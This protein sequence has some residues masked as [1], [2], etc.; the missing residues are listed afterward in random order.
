ME[1]RQLV[2]FRAVARSLSFTRAAGD[3]AYAQSSVTAQIQALEDEFGVRL[4]ERLGRRV[5]LT[6]A[7]QRLLVYAEKMLRL[8]EEAREA[9]AGGE[10]PAG[11]LTIGAYETLCVYRL[12]PALRL[13]GQRYPHLQLIV[14]L[15]PCGELRRLAASGELDLVFLLEEPADTPALH[16]EPVVPEPVLLVAPP[17]HHLTQRDAITPA[18]LEREPLLATEAGCSYRLAFERILG[19]ANISPREVMELGSVQAVKQC[20]MAGLGVALLPEVVVAEELRHGQ[21]MA[22][23][24]VGEMPHLVTQMAWHKDRWLSPALLAFVGIVRETVGAATRSESSPHQLV[25]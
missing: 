12:P 17:G 25:R 18:D 20:V 23:P 3:L 21:L 14:R 15:G 24:W 6:D 16:I 2:T 9:V 22:L 4:F 10:E 11:T 5:L 13:I 1:M 7:G 8:A 19:Q